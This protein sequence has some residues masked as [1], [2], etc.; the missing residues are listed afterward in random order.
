MTDNA[1]EPTSRKAITANLRANIAKSIAEC[2]GLTT[3]DLCDQFP[4][5]RSAMSEHC[6]G[7][8]RAHIIVRHNPPRAN[9]LKP[10][11]RWI[12]LGVDLNLITL[13][14]PSVR[15]VKMRDPANAKPQAS[16]KR[17]VK[18]SAAEQLG[19]VRDP[20]TAALFGPSRSAP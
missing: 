18:Q 13:P 9:R 10:P 11:C 19:V 4:I 1:S 7:L 16:D 15:E 14:A 12:A 8:E 17:R 5:S 6:R 3:D 20:L 2:P